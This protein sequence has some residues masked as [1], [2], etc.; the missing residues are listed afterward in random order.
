MTKL[1]SGRTALVTGSSRG[2]GRAVAQ[3]LAAEGAVVAVT[4]RSYEP[5]PS[6]RAGQATALPGTIGETIELIEAAGGKAF[7]IA[8]DLEDAEQRAALVDQV[9]ERTGRIDILVNNAGFAD[10]SIIEDMPMDTFD[11]T[12]EHYL[13]TPFVLTQAAVPHMRNQGAG[14]IVNIGSVTGLAPVR[15][16]RE[17]NKSSGDVI[18]AS[19]KA[20]LHRFTQ[21]VA[22]ELLDANIAVNA[23]GPSSAVRTPGAASLIPDTFPTEPVEYLAE[24]VLAMCHR[25]AAE[26]T[27]LVAFSLHYPWSQGLAVHSLDGRDLLPPLEPPASANPNILPAGI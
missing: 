14:W 10:Y 25:P 13:R 5:S 17:Y 18:Y 3:R 8:A 9:I 1:L 26:R 15:P 22:A 11:R 24:T 23:V 4:A 6:V 19:M 7:G 16:Y 12:V 20:A 27:G 21:G 2:I